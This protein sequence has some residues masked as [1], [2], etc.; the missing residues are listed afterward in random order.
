MPSRGPLADSYPGAVALVLLALTPYLVLTTA[1]LPLEGII[2]Q[3]VGMGQT[4]SQVT[5][6]MANAAYAVGAVLAA[7][8]ATRLPA[9]RMLVAYAVLFVAGSTLAATADLPGL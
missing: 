4:A 6:G 5:S 3:D 1:I 7:Q 9:R 8:L 2:G